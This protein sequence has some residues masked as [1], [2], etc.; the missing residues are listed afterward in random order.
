MAA[1][2][3][4]YIKLT[5]YRLI[6]IL[7][8]ERP[9]PHCAG[10]PFRLRFPAGWNAPSPCGAYWDKPETGRGVPSLSH[11]T[12]TVVTLR[13]KKR[14][15][16][17]LTVNSMRRMVVELALMNVPCKVVIRP[18]VASSMFVSGSPNGAWFKAL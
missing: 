11:G 4:T 7:E 5:H 14:Q 2:N 16:C 6:E 8:A 18:A 17:S 10:R 1:H 13:G 9:I 12:P 15:N 3:F